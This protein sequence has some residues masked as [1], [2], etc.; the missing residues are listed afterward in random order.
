MTN[1]EILYVKVTDTYTIYEGSYKLVLDDE[2][3]TYY[4]IMTRREDGS[5]GHPFSGIQFGSISDLI[6]Y[7]EIHMPSLGETLKND[8][9]VEVY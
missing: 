8:F 4:A 3:T 6:K 5:L 2:Y 1:Q 7:T 9:K